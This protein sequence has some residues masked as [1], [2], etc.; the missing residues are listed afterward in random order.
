[1]R[2]NPMK[3][4]FYVFLLVVLIPKAGGVFAQ[5]PAV[6]HVEMRDSIRLATDVYLPAGGEGPWPVVL[7]RT[8]YGRT[9]RAGQGSTQLNPTRRDS[10]LNRGVAMVIQDVRGRYDSEGDRLF[11]VA[12]GWGELQDGYDTVAWVRGQPWCNGRVATTGSSA[13]GMTQIFLAATGPEGIAGQLIHTAP[14]SVYHA[15]FSTGG[16]FRKA[17]VE[18]WLKWNGFPYESALAEWRA[19][20]YYDAYW[21]TMSLSERADRVNWPVALLCCW[22]DPFLQGSIDIYTTIRNRGGPVA[23]DNVFMVIGPYTHMNYSFRKQLTAGELEFPPDARVPRDQWPKFAHWLSHWLLGEPLDPK[24]PRVLYYVMGEAPAGNA[25]GNVWRAADDWPPPARITPWFFAAG[26]TLQTL[27]PRQEGA[28]RYLYDPQHPVPTL[29]GQNIFLKAGPY[30]QRSIEDREDVLLFTSEALTEPVEVTGRI[31]AVLYV[32]TRAKDTDFTA[33]LT[34]VYP[35]G[36]SML[37]CDSIRRLSL[38]KDLSHPQT[39][40]PGTRYRIEID[41]GSTSIV[42]NTGHRIRLAVSSSNSPRFEP[43]P[44]TGNPDWTRPETAIAEQT[45]YVGGNQASH[46]RLPIVSGR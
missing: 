7:A 20:P 45:V 24:P 38:R 5:I 22:Y 41:L 16:V 46:L 30:D 8:P 39:V 34:D 18:R 37:I 43:N 4:A 10:L 35:D 11:G 9:R 19:H 17:F 44:N 12:D 28:L 32:S 21:Q 33:K 31:T 1:M 27:P 2:E 14:L 42:L 36:R 23:R 15:F 13:G 26:H 40:V 3:R 6:Y 29:G 25:P